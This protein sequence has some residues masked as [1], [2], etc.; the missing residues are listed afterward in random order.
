MKNLKMLFKG[1][2]KFPG[3][4]LLVCVILGLLLSLLVVSVLQNYSDARGRTELH[5]KLEKL[6]DY[7]SIPAMRNRAIGVA[8]LLGLNEPLIKRAAAGET[9]LDTAEVLHRLQIARKQFDFEGMYV[10]DR[11]GLIIANDTDGKKSTG[12]S[13]AFRPYFQLAIKGQESVYLAIGTN[14]D[15]R[16]LFIAAPIYATSEKH[17]AIIGVVAIKISA[18]K[19]LSNLL[20]EVGGE[21]LLISPQGV[22]FAATRPEWQLRVTP[23]LDEERLQEIRARQQFGLRFERERPA[24][25]DF[26]PSRHFIEL[27]G[28]RFIAEQVAIDWNDSGGPWLVVLMEDSELWLPESR[29]LKIA[30]IIVFIASL[31][32]FAIQQLV[33]RTRRLNASLAGENEA[34]TKAQENIVAAAEERA[35]IAKVTAELRHAQGY[36]EL[37][38]TFMHHASQLFG[39]GFGLFYVADNTRQQLKLVGGYGV[40][41]SELGKI[42]PYGE[43]LV[44]QCALEEKALQINQPPADYIHIASGG[45]AAVPKVI[46]L[47]P[48]V[49]N[50]KLVGVL[51]LASFNMLTAKQEKMLAEFTATTAVIIEMIE[52]RQALELEFRRQQAS[53]ESLRHQASLQQ[54]LIDNI[55]YPIFYKGPDCRFLGFNRAY[56]KTFDIKREF[57]I[58][59]KVL[60]LDYLPL[61]DRTAYQQ[62][63]ERVIA[64]MAEVQ[65]EMLIPFADGELHQT[66]YCVSGFRLDDGQPGGL[67]GMFIDFTKHQ[68]GLKN[69]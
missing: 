57:L 46:L 31:M 17:S 50:E 37:V 38:Q 44:G 33:N 59:K 10:I 14:S 61:D 68:E 22:V 64:E 40:A 6:Q 28:K 4:P 16:G 63:D 47:H 11:Q 20:K 66:L 8:S 12:S 54:A 65:R 60:D 9:G 21:A 1:L 3:A 53:E 58:G 34:R 19:P 32:G 18:E 35:L 52:Q 26:D 45:G 24:E 41:I 56:E 5:I 7:L 67:V 25:L 43:S 39:I 29:K 36:T 27:E 48:L 62:E 15:T 49:L 51:E 23:P 30:G 42:V 2:Y 13:V 55:P 69:G